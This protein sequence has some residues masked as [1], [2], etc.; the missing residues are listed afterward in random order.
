[1]YIQAFMLLYMPI[2]VCIGALL[3]YCWRLMEFFCACR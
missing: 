1:M 2:Y 3:L